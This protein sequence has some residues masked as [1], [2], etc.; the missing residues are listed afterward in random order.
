MGAVA[1][2]GDDDEPA[3]ADTTPNTNSDIAATSAEIAY[4][5]L[6]TRRSS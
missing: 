1:A 6:F 3:V 5:V 2:L 4:V